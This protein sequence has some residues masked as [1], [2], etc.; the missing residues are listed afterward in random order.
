MENMLKLNNIKKKPTAPVGAQKG[1]LCVGPR[2]RG[3]TLCVKCE[4]EDESINLGLPAEEEAEAIEEIEAE[5]A[6]D[7]DAY[8]KAMEDNEPI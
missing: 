1:C 4:E 3:H 7:V 2:R 8:Y 6:E 5:M